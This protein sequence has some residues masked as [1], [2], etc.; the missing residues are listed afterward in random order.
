MKYAKILV[1]IDFSEGSD[2]ALNHALDY[3]R[4]LHSKVYL[5][6]VIQPITYPIGMEVAH[7]NF[8]EMEKEMIETSKAS[9]KA[10]A[11][12]DEYSGIEFEYDVKIGNAASVEIASYA[13]EKDID[14]ICIA[15]HGSR[16]LEHFLFGSTTEKVLRRSNCPVLVVRM[17]KDS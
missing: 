2:L 5:L 14:L 3:A 16:G 7:Y 17:K 6:H 10:I 12:K 11:Q 4:E 15:T 8:G 1:P 13:D 9:L